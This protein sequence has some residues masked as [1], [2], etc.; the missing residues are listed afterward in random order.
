[1]PYYDDT[2]SPLIYKTSEDPYLKERKAVMTKRVCGPLPLEADD[3]DCRIHEREE[4]L[5]PI[6]LHTRVM[7][8][9]DIDLRS[10]S[11]GSIFDLHVS[12]RPGDAP[13]DDFLP[14]IR[15][16]EAVSSSESMRVSIN[17]DY[18]GHAFGGYR[19]TVDGR[20]RSKMDLRMFPFDAQALMIEMQLGRCKNSGSQLLFSRGFRL[21]H[22]PTEPNV[23]VNQIDSEYSFRPCRFSLSLT[24]PLESADRMCK[25][26]L[27]VPCERD[28]LHYL[29]N[30]YVFIGMI[31]C[32][33]C[34]PPLK[35]QFKNIKFTLTG[36]DPAAFDERRGLRWYTKLHSRIMLPPE[37]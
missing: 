20:F 8:I 10:Q 34:T 29:L 14:I 30:H 26:E 11:F 16:P 23:L 18:I 37:V 36:P 22:H 31:A 9:T 17:E 33:D 28:P 4:R 21:A 27:W 7:S 5:K 25:Y 19:T 6:F 15:F 3:A 24:G 13:T 2:Y 35:K 12:W 32:M 1:M